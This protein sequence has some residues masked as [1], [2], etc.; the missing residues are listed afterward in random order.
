VFFFRGPPSLLFSPKTGCAPPPPHPSEDFYALPPPHHPPPPPPKW[1]SFSPVTASPPQVFF[2]F[3]LHH[4]HRDC[5]PV[6]LWTVVPSLPLVYK[7]SAHIPSSGRK[8]SIFAF[9]G[10]VSFPPACDPFS[11]PL[12]GLLFWPFP[13]HK[14]EFAVPVTGKWTAELPR[15]STLLYVSVLF[16]FFPL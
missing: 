15:L 2:F 1:N 5:V 16:S 14:Y 3:F 11:L 7:L 12:L 4:H 13:P 10:V 9:S 8:N 6:L